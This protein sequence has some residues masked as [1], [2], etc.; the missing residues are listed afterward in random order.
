M[1]AFIYDMDGVIVDTEPLHMEA[2][3]HVLNKMGVHDVTIKDLLKYQGTTDLLVY[4]DLKNKRGFLRNRSRLCV[5]KTMSSSD[6]WQK[7]G[8][9]PSRGLST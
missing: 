1:K 8:C 2:I 6:C 5:R 4:E 9:S 3:V 7:K